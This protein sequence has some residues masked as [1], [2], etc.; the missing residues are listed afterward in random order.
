MTTSPMQDM[1][2]PIAAAKRLGLHERTFRR[3]MADGDIPVFRVGRGRTYVRIADVDA[4]VRRIEP[5]E[6]ENLG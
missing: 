1:I 2:P 3:Y 6:V 5:S 4:L